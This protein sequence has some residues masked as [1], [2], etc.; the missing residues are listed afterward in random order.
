MFTSILF[1]ACGVLALAGA[2]GNFKHI[3]SFLFINKYIIEVLGE[4][5]RIAYQKAVVKPWAITGAALLILGVFTYFY[6]NRVYA[7]LILGISAYICVCGGSIGIMKIN[8]KYGG[9]YL[10]RNLEKR[11]R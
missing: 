5:E 7:A 8:K 6:Y 3:K 4:S 1:I 11:N 2:I 10:P 9:C